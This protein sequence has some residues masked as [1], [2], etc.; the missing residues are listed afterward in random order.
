M[1]RQPSGAHDL[2]LVAVAQQADDLRRAW[3]LKPNVAH[4]AAHKIAFRTEID[5]AGLRKPPD[6]G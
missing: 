3:F 2:L 6:R 5:H 1:G 4:A